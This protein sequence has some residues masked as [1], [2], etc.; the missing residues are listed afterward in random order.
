MQCF[1]RRIRLSNRACSRYGRQI[2]TSPRHDSGHN[3][4]SKIGREKAKVDSAKSKQTGVLSHQISNASK[5][6]GPDPKQNAQ[7]ADLVATAKRAGMPKSSIEVAILRGQG[8]S[9]TG[10]TL[11]RVTIEAVV[12]PVGFIVEAQTDK[13]SQMLQEVRQMFKRYGGNVALTAYLFQRRGRITIEGAKEVRVDDLLDLALDVGALDVVEGADGRVIVDT[14]P[15]ALKPVETALRER[16]DFR[17]GLS[18]TVWHPNSDTVTEH[19]SD[20]TNEQIEMLT[21]DLEQYPGVEGVFTN[22]GI[23]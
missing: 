11:E 4:W 14:D 16:G 5:A 7:L 13:K 15:V 3:R 19:L 18:E 8:K 9:A 6:D 12:P 1:S 23:D 2:S 21:Q 20:Q 10:A 22:V 17:V